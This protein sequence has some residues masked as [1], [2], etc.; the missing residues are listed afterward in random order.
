MFINNIKIHYYDKL[1]K[2]AIQSEN[3]N[4]LIKAFKGLKKNE[5]LL[6][7]LLKSNIFKISENQEFIDFFPQNILWVNSFRTNETTLVS[8]FLDYYFSKIDLPHVPH[9]NYA[10]SLFDVFDD[11]KIKENI[12]FAEISNFAY[13]YQYMIASSAPVKLITLNSNAAFFETKIGRHFTHFFLTRAFIY[14]VKN[15]YE[16]YKEI[17]LTNP[18]LDNHSAINLLLNLDLSVSKVVDTKSKREYEENRQGW[19]VNVSSWIN[20][21]VANTFK[22]L[23]LKIEDVLSSPETSL[24]EVIAH[25]MQSGLKIKLDYDIIRDFISENQT[26]FKPNVQDY[27]ISNNELKILN[28]EIGSLVDKLKYSPN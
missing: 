26:Y 23:I 5:P 11:L 25:L 27:S 16:I 19:G 10:A 6:L 24:A 22:G 7:Q 9:T 12:T 15:P 17:K 8:K 4:D 18:G 3:K 20:P 13:V 2:Q 28:R 1:I 14:I 21:N